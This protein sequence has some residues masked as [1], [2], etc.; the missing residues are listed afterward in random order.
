MYRYIYIHSYIYIYICISGDIVDFNGK[1][2][3]KPAR[4][5]QVLSLAEIKNREAGKIQVFSDFF[6]VPFLC[7]KLNTFSPSPVLSCI[8]MN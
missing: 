1:K 8:H 5:R 6:F 4:N 3:Q 2:A 7:V